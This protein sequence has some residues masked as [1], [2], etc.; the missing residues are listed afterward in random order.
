VAAA[1]GNRRAQL[2]HHR[3]T[4]GTTSAESE[5]PQ[6]FLNRVRQFLNL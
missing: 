3:A 6:T 2:E 5:T 4:R 1:V